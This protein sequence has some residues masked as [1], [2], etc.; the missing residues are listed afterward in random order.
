MMSVWRGGEVDH[1]RVTRRC[2]ICVCVYR[3]GGA[4]FNNVT[5][6]CDV[7]GRGEETGRIQYGDTYVCVCVREGK[8][9]DRLR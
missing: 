9:K 7:C 6:C 2:N 4:D 8:G 1:S 3:G 5:R